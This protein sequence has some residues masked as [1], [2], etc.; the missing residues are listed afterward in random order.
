M[1]TISIVKMASTVLKTIRKHAYTF[2]TSRYSNP[3]NTRN[4]AAYGR[5]WFTLANMNID[6][7]LVE[8]REVLE[9]EKPD[10]N[11]RQVNVVPI[12]TYGTAVFE[13]IDDRPHTCYRRPDGELRTYD[14]VAYVFEYVLENMPIP[15]VVDLL[16]EYGADPNLN[17]DGLLLKFS[18]LSSDSSIDRR[19]YDEVRYILTALI[20]HGLVINDV[21]PDAIRDIGDLMI[22]IDLGYKVTDDLLDYV[23]TRKRWEFISHMQFVQVL[24]VFRSHGIDVVK[25]I[26]NNHSAYD[27]DD[28]DY[29]IVY[30][31]DEF[32]HKT[33]EIYP[34]IYYKVLYGLSIDLVTN[35]Q[36]EQ[37]LF[38]AILLDNKELADLLYPHAG[39]R[40]ALEYIRTNYLI[41][42]KFVK[43]ELHDEDTLDSLLAECHDRIANDL[44]LDD[45]DRKFTDFYFDYMK[46]LGKWDTYMRDRKRLNAEYMYAVDTFFEKRLPRE[47]NRIIMIYLA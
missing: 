46:F 4:V 5:L 36:L 19:Y 14:E 40:D 3:A 10:L 22:F 33:I 37:C 17:Y 25:H 26:G 21:H 2:L 1:V 9:K 8:L 47:I 20:A 28:Y 15:Q 44:E 41:L 31:G 45:D 35:E 24:D 6:A 30:F 23:L 12:F 43:G 13:D 34:L 7:M 27:N 32:Y 11:A 16:L 42:Q 38:Y 18:L 39:H 29:S